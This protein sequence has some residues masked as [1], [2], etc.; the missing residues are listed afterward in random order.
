MYKKE[1][2]EKDGYSDSDAIQFV[3]SQAGQRSF[4]LAENYVETL[5]EDTFWKKLDWYVYAE[6]MK[7]K[8]YNHFKEV[9]R[10]EMLLNKLLTYFQEKEENIKNKKMNPEEQG[11]KEQDNQE[12]YDKVNRRLQKKQISY[13]DR[14]LFLV[15]D[16]IYLNRNRLF[17]A[18][19]SY[20]L[21]VI[22]KQNETVIT[23]A[24]LKIMLLT[25]K[26][27]YP[28]VPFNTENE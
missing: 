8:R 22:S 19:K 10:D 13:K 26:D 16:Y 1:H 12:L 7:S 2:P 25:L 24:L 15:C 18:G 23:E 14:V 20:P 11:K 28:Q 6:N 21:F 27:L 9:Y 3:F 4:S 17:H 5:K